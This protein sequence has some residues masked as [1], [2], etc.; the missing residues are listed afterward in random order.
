M[1]SPKYAEVITFAD[2][3]FTSAAEEAKFKYDGTA[4]KSPFYSFYTDRNYFG[5]SQSLHDKLFA[6][7][8]PRDSIYFKAPTGQTSVEFAPNGLVMQAQNKY[9]ISAISDIKAPTFLMSYHELQ[10]LKAEAYARQGAAFLP[11]ATAA[12]K[13]AITAS[14]AKQNIGLSKAKAE[15]YFDEKVSGKLGTP[16]S[17]LEE[18]MVQKYLAFYEEEAVE[19]YNDYRRL[20]AM[21]NNFIKLDNPLKFPLRFTY[22]SEDVTTNENVRT[23]YGDGSYVYTENVWWAGGTR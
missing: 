12:L 21:G 14:F 6:K 5:A 17:A 23:A 8:D 19:A 22:G 11:Q 16:N 1:K 4:S 15:A 18:I 9:G 10:F 3:S 20:K 2:K 7:S 13:S